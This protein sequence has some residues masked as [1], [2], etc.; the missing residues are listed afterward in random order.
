MLALEEPVRIL[1]RP[2]FVRQMTAVKRALFIF[3]LSL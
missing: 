1:S 3:F 2:V